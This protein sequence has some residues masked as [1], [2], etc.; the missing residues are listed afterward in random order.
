MKVLFAV[1]GYKPAYRVGGPIYS[2]S[3]LA[4]GLATRG[5]KVVVFTTNSNLDQDLDVPTDRPIDVNGVEVW[6]FRR[7]SF[8]KDRLPFLPYVAKSLGFLYAP[9]MGRELERL[10]PD[11]DLVHT[12][13]PFNFPSLAAARAAFRHRKP[14]FYHQRGVLDPERLKF[15]ALKKR[16]YV[17]VVEKPIMK[18]ATTLI[19]LTRAEEK[20]YRRLGI[21]THISV[22]PNGILVDTQE[23]VGLGAARLRI[24]EGAPVILFMG[25]IHPIK[26]ADVVLEAFMTLSSEIQDAV[27]VL[28]GPDEFGLER[29]FRD[30]V[31]SRGLGDRVLFTGMVSG[32]DKQALLARST[33]FCLPSVAE[34]FSIAVLE[35]LAS[36]VPVLISPGCH[37]P[38]VEEFDAGRVVDRTPTAVAEAA[39][40]LL[41]NTDRL[42]AMGRRAKALAAE[43]YA[44]SRVIEQMIDVYQEG[45]D[46]HRQLS[47]AQ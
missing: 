27:L 18:R 41:R 36:G 40:E 28:A 11:V 31:H 21:A 10:V 43:R 34:G 2:V 4:E 1:H 47:R 35:A 15:R 45:I 44:W 5:H 24:P 38:E 9:L 17:E 23:A 37:F 42:H 12:H 14:L 19:A 26:G 16:V 33:L 30:A 7:T 29:R 22:V 13:M 25:R 6:Y 46:R 8:L 20:S 39:R 3:A 32:A